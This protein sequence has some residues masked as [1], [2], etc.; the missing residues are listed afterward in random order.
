MAFDTLA[1]PAEYVP[2]ADPATRALLFREAVTEL[3]VLDD[4]VA[5]N[6]L[7]EIDGFTVTINDLTGHFPSEVVTADQVRKETGPQHTRVYILGKTIARATL[8]QAEDLGRE[9][10]LL[11]PQQQARPRQFTLRLDNLSA[12]QP[13]V[14]FAKED[15]LQ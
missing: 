1:A 15:T 4:P 3:I 11:R 8:E 5:V 13:I 10:P 6:R 12:I 9:V 14:E 2:T 7:A